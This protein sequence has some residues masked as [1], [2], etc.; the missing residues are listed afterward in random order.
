MAL[1]SPCLRPKIR[2]M[3]SVGAG[4]RTFGRGFSR[5]LRT[6]LQYRHAEVRIERGCECEGD[7]RRAAPARVRF[8]LSQIPRPPLA[9]S[10][11]TLAVP[12]DS[13]RWLLSRT[14]AHAC[15]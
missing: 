14:A 7:H 12:E 15:R 10:S 4:R 11:L 5:A 9:A 3:S 1:A 13:T 2:N 6:R 8:V